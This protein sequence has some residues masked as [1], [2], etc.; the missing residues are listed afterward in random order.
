MPVEITSEPAFIVEHVVDLCV[1]VPEERCNFTL[2]EGDQ[3]NVTEDGGSLIVLWSGHTIVFNMA[4]VS[5]YDVQPREIKT[6]I[7]KPVIAPVPHIVRPEA[8][9][10]GSAL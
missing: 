2:R 8:L 7:K 5:Y 4:R 10:D 9:P 3:W 6:P 1:Q